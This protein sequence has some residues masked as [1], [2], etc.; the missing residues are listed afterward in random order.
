[1]CSQVCCGTRTVRNRKDRI[2]NGGKRKRIPNE[3]RRSLRESV[4]RDSVEPTMFVVAA[5]ADRG[6]AVAG[7][8]PSRTGIQGQSRNCRIVYDTNPSKLA[9][10]GSAEAFLPVVDAGFSRRQGALATTTELV[11]RDS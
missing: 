9:V 1:R 11:G 3:R 5:V 7:L 10:R 2:R 6:S 4:G 8:G